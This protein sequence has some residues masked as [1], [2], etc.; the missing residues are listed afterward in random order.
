M[1]S[2]D[3]ADFDP[4]WSF[5]DRDDG[6]SLCHFLSLPLFLPF[7]L[8]FLLLLSFLFLFLSLLFLLYSADGVVV[9]VVSKS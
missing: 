1:G 3:V 2:L 6:H 4:R 8:L 9:V 5:V 7:H